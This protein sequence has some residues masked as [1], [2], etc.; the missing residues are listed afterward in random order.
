MHDSAFTVAIATSSSRILDPANSLRQRAGVLA[1]RKVI[2]QL[3]AGLSR[4]PV[5]GLLAAATSG[6]VH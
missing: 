4:S 3:A 6:S 5:R 1:A 2:G